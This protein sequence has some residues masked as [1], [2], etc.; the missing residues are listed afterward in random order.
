M[1]M[2]IKSFKIFFQANKNIYN[3]FSDKYFHAYKNFSYNSQIIAK[4]HPR[5]PIWAFLEVLT[6]GD[7]IKFYRYYYTQHN[8]KIPFPEH[9]ES[10]RILR[11]ATAHNN[12]LLNNLTKKRTI[13]SSN[14]IRSILK[15]S[16]STKQL[17]PV[18][19]TNFLIMDII[20]TYYLFINVSNNSDIKNEIYTEL[21]GKVINR[22][23]AH[24]YFIK[25]EN[26]TDCMNFLNEAI[27]IIQ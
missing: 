25:N 15:N 14:I 18:C 1:M 5:Y 27:K 3:N 12:C 8:I 20:S 6:F 17:Y 22:F 2:A 13:Q 4:Y 23:F 9:L 7:F 24:N 10:A 11:N 26:M 21:T 19:K 16:L